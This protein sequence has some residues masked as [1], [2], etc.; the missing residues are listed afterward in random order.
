M[1]AGFNRKDDY[2]PLIFFKESIKTGRFKGEKLVKE[3]YEKMLKEYYE[4]NGWDKFSGLQFRDYLHQLG[5]P[6]IS[7]KLEQFLKTENNI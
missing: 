5:L 6:E 1:H 7:D 4:A 2:P 3:K